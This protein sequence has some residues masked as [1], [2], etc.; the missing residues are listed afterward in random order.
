M[1]HSPVRMKYRYMFCKLAS[2]LWYMLDITSVWCP[3]VD[4]LVDL[5]TRVDALSRQYLESKVAVELRGEKAPR[6]LSEWMS[7]ECNGAETDDDG[8][9]GSESVTLPSGP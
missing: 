5:R 8:L 1:R 7:M 3:D 9:I 2:W 6:H 4:F